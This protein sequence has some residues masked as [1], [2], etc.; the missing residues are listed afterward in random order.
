MD[1]REL[2]SRFSD[3]EKRLAV[4]EARLGVLQFLAQTALGAA[5]VQLIATVF[6][7]IGSV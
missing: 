5:I 3:L 4:L 6:R 2:Y 7:A 1:D